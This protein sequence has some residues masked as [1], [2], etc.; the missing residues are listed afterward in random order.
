[1]SSSIFDL[2]HLTSRLIRAGGEAETGA[3]VAGGAAPPGGVVTGVDG[4]AEGVDPVTEPGE[5]AGAETDP[6]TV[7]SSVPFPPPPLPE[8]ELE[9]DPEPDD[10]LPELSSA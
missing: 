3:F 1:M 7:L 9:P 4:W 8:L 5:E 6:G 2:P 10:P